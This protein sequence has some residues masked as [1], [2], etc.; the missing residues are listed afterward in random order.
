MLLATTPVYASWGT[1]KERFLG[2]FSAT[3]VV[4]QAQTAQTMALLQ[5]TPSADPKA[6]L[7]GGDITIVNDSALLPDSGPLGT[8]AD[9]AEI[10]PSDQISIYVVRKGDTLSDI[11]KMFNVSA[12]TILWANDLTRGTALKEGQVLTILP[13]SG[14]RYTVKKGDTLASIAKKYKGDAEEIAQFN[15]LDHGASL[16]VGQV[17]IVPDGELMATPTKS[18]DIKPGSTLATFIGNLMRPITGGRKTQGIHGF[19]GVDLASRLGAEVFAASSGNV[20]IARSGGW[21]GGYGS[22]VVVDHGN[23]VQTLYAHLSAVKVAQGQRVVQGQVIGALGNSG[24]S[25]G[26]HLHFEVRGAKNPF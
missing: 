22:Y 19:N 12:N 23:G 2:T 5:A 26:P 21:N 15:G 1:L 13:I 18:P 14:V 25:T 20:I 7:G 6:A 17:V 11:A 9:I 24:R 16:A 10:P 8:I 3:P 4:G